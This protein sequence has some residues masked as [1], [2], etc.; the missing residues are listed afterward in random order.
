MAEGKKKT[1][2]FG[3]SELGEIGDYNKNKNIKENRY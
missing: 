2:A 1:R 3:M